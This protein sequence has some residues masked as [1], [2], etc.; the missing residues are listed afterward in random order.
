M[1]FFVG[2][3]V[4]GEKKNWKRLLLKF[5]DI[6]YLRKFR[7]NQMWFLLLYYLSIHDGW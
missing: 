4:M 7:Q 5:F 3:K 2:A 1:L 6:S